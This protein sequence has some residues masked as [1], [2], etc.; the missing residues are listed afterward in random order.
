MKMFFLFYF[1]VFLS[2]CSPA[3]SKG[4]VDWV[5]RVVPKESGKIEIDAKKYLVGDCEKSDS[6]ALNQLIDVASK[7]GSTNE[8]VRILL[9]VPSG[10][11]YSFEEP[12]VL[13]SNVDLEPR[14]NVRLKRVGSSRT[15]FVAKNIQN[16]RLGPFLVD[17]QGSTRPIVADILMAS[18]VD[19][20]D[21]VG[22]KVVNPVGSFSFTDSKNVLIKNISVENSLMHGVRLLR[23]HHIAVLDSYFQN[24]V[25]FGVIVDDGSSHTLIQGNKTT[26][27]GL[28]LVGVVRSATNNK[29]IGNHAEGTGD[30]CISISGEGNLV[31]GNVV[32][33]CA[34]VGIFVYGKDNKIV[35]NFSKNNNKG[36]ARNP[37][38]NAGIKIQGAFGGVGA[39]NVVE[40]NEVDDDQDSPTQQY[41]I[42]VDKPIYKNWSPNSETK[43]GS[44]V[45]LG[46]RVY[47]AQNQGRTGRT[48][49]ICKEESCYDS[50]V[51][52]IF[53]Q[54]FPNDTYATQNNKVSGNI[55]RKSA[56]SAYHDRAKQGSN[57]IRY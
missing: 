56:V 43:A 44:Y 13:K 52:W 12:I 28:E 2:M 6:K 20:V 42:L 49:P 8:R 22:V 33:N 5:S 11:C 7:Q 3:F 18:N 19:D 16:F 41:G 53:C 26:K 21:I 45:L 23:S 54:E 15:V 31:E 47:R 37:A 55:V 57:E 25:G 17:Q 10:G 32:Q 29:V 35:K 38:W 1:L 27:N 9:P 34:G 14:G 48:P 36:F 50:E 30:N 39:N 4:T 24:N 46:S 51:I 40:D